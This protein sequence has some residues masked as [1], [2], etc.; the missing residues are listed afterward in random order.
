MLTVQ[1]RMLNKYQALDKKQQGMVKSVFEDLYR[2][3]AYRT[4]CMMTGKLHY[5]GVTSPSKTEHQV[6]RVH[7]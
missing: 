6:H 5:H 1:L 2:S 4:N 7:L 3:A